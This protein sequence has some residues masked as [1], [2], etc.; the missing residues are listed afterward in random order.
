MIINKKRFGNIG[1]E[2][3]SKYLQ[4]I[5]YKIIERNF[6]CRQGEIDII[7]KDKDELV[8]I[9]VKTRS[10]LFFG[11]P[12]EAVNYY[13]QKH[14]LKSTKYYLYIHKLNNCFIRFDIIEVYFKNHKYRLNHIKNVEIKPL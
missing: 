4:Q 10:S 13:K 7:A 3:S 6:N 5:G 9:E 11:K 2:I 8:F 14:I 1:E 12:K